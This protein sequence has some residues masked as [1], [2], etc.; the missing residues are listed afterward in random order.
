MRHLAC[1]L[2]APLCCQISG[3]SPLYADKP[4]LQKTKF[5]RLVIY[6]SR[7]LLQA[8]SR[9]RL[10]KKYTVSIGKGTAGPK[11]HHGDNRTPEG[12]YR[13]SGR[14][15]SKTYYLFLSLSYPNATDRRRYSQA[16]KL[17]LIPKGAGIGTAVGIHGEHVGLT[18]LPHK[19]VNWTRGCI[20]LDNDE[21]EE[22][23]RAVIPGAEVVIHP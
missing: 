22:L 9:G 13:I 2:F 11:L 23:Y 5:D 6:K 1:L 3:A 10:L 15:R 8:W 12:T 7:R 4:I 17:G 18:W 20:A 21:I 16:K 14:H 19:W